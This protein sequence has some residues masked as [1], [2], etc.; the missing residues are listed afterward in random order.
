MQM[1]KLTSAKFKK[2]LSKL[3]HIENS[4]FLKANNIDAD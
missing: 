2:K 3:Y 4:N 1:A